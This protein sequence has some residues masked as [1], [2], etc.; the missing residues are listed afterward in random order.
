MSFLARSSSGLRTVSDRVHHEHHHSQL[1]SVRLRPGADAFERRAVPLTCSI[2]PTEDGWSL[3]A[4]NG[5]VVFRGLGTAS[6]RQ[7]L[8]FARSHGVLVV[9]S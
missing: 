9:V 5:Q 6:R 4:P 7:C 8:E 3:L 2:R 1:G